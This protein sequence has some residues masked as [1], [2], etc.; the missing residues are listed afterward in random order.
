MTTL[1]DDYFSHIYVLNLDRRPD[2]WVKTS[3]RLRPLV[4]DFSNNVTRFS[5][6]DGKNPEIINSWR[7][8]P[9]FL[10]NS[11]VLAVLMSVQKIL[12]DAAMKG[13]KRFLL[14]EDD[15]VFHRD[16]TSQWSRITVPG[17][18]PKWKLLFLG[19]SMHRWRFSDRCRY[20]KDRGY[21][22]STGSIP[23]AFALGIDSS[24]IK[25]LWGGILYGKSAWDLSPLKT[26]NVKYP[27]SCLVLHPQLCIATVDDSDLRNR[28]MIRKAHDCYWDLSQFDID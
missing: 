13:F 2:R 24:V 28:D 21:L 16:F 7:R 26:V 5:A 4:R 1:L 23:G 17:N 22:T 8:L 11:G 18:L 19:N 14:L 12:H 6:V 15:V 9:Y 10:T 20:Y 27:G 3:Q 25:D